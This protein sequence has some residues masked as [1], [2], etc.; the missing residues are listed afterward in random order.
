MDTN[1]HAPMLNSMSGYL[2]QSR[3]DNTVKKYN[4]SFKHFDEFCVKNKLSSKP[5]LPISVAMY[6]TTLLDEGK[7]VSVISAA[8]YGIKWA[9]NISG[10][11]DPTEHSI[12]K[13]LLECAKHIQSKPVQKKD[14]LSTEMLTNLCSMY[15][16]CDDVIELRDLSMIMIAYSGFMRMNEITELR[17]ND[18]RF[19]PDYLSIQIRSSKTD[20]YRDGSEVVI[21]KG[22]SVACPLSLLQRYISVSGISLDSSDYLFKPGFVSK[23]KSSLIK[24]NKRLS[25]TRAK[26][27]IVKKL[28]MVAPDLKL[29]T[30]SLRA[31][32]VTAAAS[33]AAISERCLKRHG[34]WKT[35]VA[36]D[37]Y[38]KDSLD[39]RLSVAKNLKL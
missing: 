22:T 31:S 23:Q 1:E 2:L 3:A 39:T 8:F 7:S 28:K 21:C 20:I 37:S 27:C 32:G 17:C 5:A 14:V 6:L 12:A 10:F 16:T 11:D 38:I 34:R 15:V 18:L 29:G 25:Y 24:K 35:D 36:K 4:S 30:H 9:H 33:S 13:R 19:H 26:E